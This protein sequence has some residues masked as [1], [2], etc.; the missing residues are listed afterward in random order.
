MELQRKIAKKTCFLQEGK[1]HITLIFKDQIK[2]CNSMFFGVDDIIEVDL[3]EFDASRVFSMSYMFAN[4]DKLKKINFGNINTSSVEKME[5]LFSGCSSLTS[6]DLSNFDTSNVE[7]M[8]SMFSFCSNLKYLDLSNFNTSKVTTIYKMFYYCSSLI[9]LNLYQFQMNSSAN[10]SHAFDWISD[11]V[12]YCI[13]D[14]ETKNYL[15]GNNTISI[16]SDT[17]YNESNLKGYIDNNINMCIESCIN[18]G[19]K[20]EYNNIC[21]NKCPK[22]TILNGNLCE[23]YK[24]VNNE[25]NYCGSLYNCK[26]SYYNNNFYCICSY[27]CKYHRPIGYYLDID[28]GIYKKCYEN[29]EFCIG[30]GNE[31]INNCNEC[32]S[33]YTFLNES[34]YKT[35]CYEECSSIF[36][37][38]KYYYYYYFDEFNEYHCT[39]KLECPSKYNILIRAKNKCIDKCKND[40]IYK[41]EYKK[42]C[43]TKC[44]GE[45]YILEDKN[46]YLCYNK[47]PDGYYLDKENNI[48]KKC[49]ESCFKCDTG[50]NETIHNCK[51]CKANYT[52]YKNS[53]YISNCYP[54]CKYY[55][56]FDESNNFHCNK[57][58]PE[59]YKLIMNKNKCIDDCKNDDNY[60]YEY[61]NICYSKCPNNT[62]TLEY[63]K[64]NYCYDNPPN[65]YYLD[66]KN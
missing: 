46:D 64:N 59:E 10:K 48:F 23:D 29:C 43:Y 17:C 7:T 50:G 22:G 5:G 25:D 38:Y 62:Y 19:Y 57:T 9:Y 56:Y 53:K 13:K 39:D 55:Y 36:I 49:Y 32:N 47:T 18:I 14:T 8:K 63:K 21:F 3:T 41:Y 15:L 40:D 35:N 24:C 44:P 45:T 12:K 37:S 16:C 27:Y 4:C 26:Y 51:E 65:D 66:F 58:C 20:Y 1:N 60:K 6:I 52:S 2:T 31:T 30:E 42:N 34:K 54:K 33:G 28:D 61:K 11:N